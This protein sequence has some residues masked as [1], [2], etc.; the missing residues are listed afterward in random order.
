MKLSQ[1]K[2]KLP[3]ELIAQYPA[4][5]RDESRLMVVDSKKGT[6]E[7][8]VFKEI[9]QYFDACTCLF[10]ITTQRC[11]RR[12]CLVIKKRQV[13]ASKCSCSEN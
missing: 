5:N 7:H 3:E 6:I 4:K 2:F 10:F 12:D 9:L 1:F 13:H 8:K 11:S